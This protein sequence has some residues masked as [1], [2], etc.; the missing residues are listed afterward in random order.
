M[1]ED[2]RPGGFLLLPLG[3]HAR[4]GLATW[5]DGALAVLPVLVAHENATTRLAWP[6]IAR[7]AALVRMGKEAV[8]EAC[9]KLEEWKWCARVS[10]PGGGWAWEMKYASYH[11]GELSAREYI[12]LATDMIMRGAWAACPPSARRL[13]L[14]LR[15]LAVIG[16]RVDFDWMPEDPY[17]QIDPFELEDFAFFPAASWVPSELRRLTGLPERTMR[18]AQGW[19]MENGFMRATDS[20]ADEE[21]GLILPFDPERYSPAV[22][23]RLENIRAEAGSRPEGYAAQSFHALKKASRKAASKSKWLNARRQRKASQA[24]TTGPSGG[25]HRPGTIL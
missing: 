25:N 8:R 11:G 2:D 5:P 16:N 21:P 10:R 3:R 23:E 15:G 7:M 9:A 24:A 17:G 6:S 13:Y 1:A 19:L 4:E 14:T 22:L 20:S 12:R 18:H